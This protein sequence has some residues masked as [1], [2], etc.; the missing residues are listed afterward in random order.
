MTDPRKA[1]VALKWAVR[2]ME[3]RYKKMS[4][5]GVRNIDGYNTRV[6]EARA[7]G[8]VIMRDV[9]VGWDP[10]T[11]QPIMGEEAMSLDH[12]PFIVVIVDEMADLMMVAART[13]KAPFSASP[14]WPAPPAST[15]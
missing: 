13:S 1:V 10:S 8:E 4:R 9:E 7:K 3:S 12:L 14:R 15:S 2:E 6:A 11:G 5:L